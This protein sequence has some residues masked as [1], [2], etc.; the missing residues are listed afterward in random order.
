MNLSFPVTGDNYGGVDR[1]WFAHEDDI[2]GVDDQG[3]IILRSGAYWNLGRAV[4]YTLDFQHPQ[5]TRRG[6][7]VY[8]PSLSGVVKKYRPEL[9]QVIAKMQGERFA[10]IIKDKNG[11]LLQVGMPGELLTFS[12]DLATG[13]MPYENN[14]YKF[15]FR[16]QTTAKPVNFLKEIETDPSIPSEPV[17]GSP[18]LIYLNGS[19]AASVPAGGTFA[20]TTEF[21]LEYTIL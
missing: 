13:A 17:I 20:I 15:G 16:G 21:T 9:E 2:E 5:N 8:A 1:F 7:N 14:E 6:G 12:T 11:Y 3:Q 19:L 10:I 4:K 18:V